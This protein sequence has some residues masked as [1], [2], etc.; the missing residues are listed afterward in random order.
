MRNKKRK[1]NN[2]LLDDTV[3]SPKTNSREIETKKLL[4]ISYNL[5]KCLNRVCGT[6]LCLGH[7]NKVAIPIT[8]HF[9]FSYIYLVC[10]CVSLY[11][12]IPLKIGKTAFLLFFSFVRKQKCVLFSMKWQRKQEKNSLN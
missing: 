10:L 8:I 4:S 9:N 2:I 3:V 11:K 5:N 7:N 1:K 6:R 12:T